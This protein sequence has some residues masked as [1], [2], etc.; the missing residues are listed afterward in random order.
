MSNLKGG[1]KKDAKM[2]I[3]AFPVSIYT[4]SVSA[5]TLTVRRENRGWQVYASKDVLASWSNEKT[6]SL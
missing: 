5:E 3:R 6:L 4:G 1:T 2:R